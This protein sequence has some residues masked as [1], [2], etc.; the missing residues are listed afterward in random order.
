[1]SNFGGGGQLR[2]P[3]IRDD[4]GPQ[5]VTK[6]DNFATNERPP[7]DGAV[8]LWAD[9]DPATKLNTTG[10]QRSLRTKTREVQYPFGFP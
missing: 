9:V 2:P 8:F 3:A 6:P 10:H 7:H 5:N 1:L 4:I